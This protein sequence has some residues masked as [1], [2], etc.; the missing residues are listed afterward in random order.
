MKI[1]AVHCQKN[2][3]LG[4]FVSFSLFL[5]GCL[6]IMNQNEKQTAQRWIGRQFRIVTDLYVF[7]GG[8][9]PTYMGANLGSLKELPHEVCEKNVGEE[10]LN[11]RIVGIVRSGSI[12]TVDKVRYTRPVGAKNFSL[13]GRVKGTQSYWESIDVSFLQQGRNGETPADIV[14]L[15]QVFQEVKSSEPK[16]GEPDTSN[17]QGSAP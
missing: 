1:R 12:F 17:A 2:G 10:T 3:L 9:G 16:Q 4:L 14:L 6:A 13:V 5:G 8:E 7:T 15:P 11:Y